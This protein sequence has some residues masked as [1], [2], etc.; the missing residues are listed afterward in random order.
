M[1]LEVPVK[2][3]LKNKGF[4]LVELLIVITILSILAAMAIPQLFPQ[5][6]KGRIGEAMTIL[7]AMRQS[8]EAYYLENG[9]YVA[10]SAATPSDW[11]DKLRMESPNVSTSRF[12]TYRVSLTGGGTGFDA[13]AQR[14]TNVSA[15]VASLYKNKTFG[16]NQNGNWIDGSGGTGPH[17]LRPRNP[18]GS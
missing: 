3:K 5:T 6:E 13:V 1:I 16:I 9:A 11:Q 8:E 14:D 18:D 10:A 4:T 7:S 2:N 17:P 12:F 15:A